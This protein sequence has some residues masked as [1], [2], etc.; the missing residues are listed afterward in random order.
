M[1]LKARPSRAVIPQER[2]PPTTNVWSENILSR[3]TYL[4]SFDHFVRGDLVGDLLYP[5]RVSDLPVGTHDATEG[6]GRLGLRGEVHPGGQLFF[7]SPLPASIGQKTKVQ[8]ERGDFV[9]SFF[10]SKILICKGSFLQGGPGLGGGP[11]THSFPGLGS[12]WPPRRP[13]PRGPRQPR[14][15]GAPRHRRPREAPS[16]ARSFPFLLSQWNPTPKHRGPKF[17]GF[18]SPASPLRPR[19]GQREASN[20]HPAGPLRERR[21]E[22]YR[23]RL[24]PQN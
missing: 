23:A 20:P 3:E 9:T 4:Q 10:I 18:E 21:R 14:A 11:P 6:S 7:H 15:L 2:A 17:G 19:F 22:A 13:H 8:R 5:R 24:R 16:R 1:K 12:W